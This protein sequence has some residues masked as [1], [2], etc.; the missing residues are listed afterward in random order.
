MMLRSFYDQCLERSF[1]EVIENLGNVSIKDL[2]TKVANALENPETELEESKRADA[3]ATRIWTAMRKELIEL[4]KK[5]SIKTRVVAEIEYLGDG[6]V[7]IMYNKQYCKVYKR[8]D[9]GKQMDFPKVIFGVAIMAEK[10][11][12][13]M[14]PVMSR[15]RGKHSDWCVEFTPAKE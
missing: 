11:H 15:L 9:I 8:Y 1:I 5:G 2:G 3:Q 12:F 13:S 7:S 14:Y 6:K 10:F 4:A